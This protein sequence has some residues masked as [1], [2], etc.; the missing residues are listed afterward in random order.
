[1]RWI[2]GAVVVVVRGAPATVPVASDT[3]SSAPPRPSVISCL[4]LDLDPYRPPAAAVAPTWLT[5]HPPPV[6]LATIVV[7][8]L[9]ICVALQVCLLADH[10]VATPGYLGVTQAAYG[11][12]FHAPLMHAIVR[13]TGLA[14]TASG[15]LFLVWL[16]FACRTVRELEPRADLTPW[17]IAWFFVPF[18]N[19]VLPY[20]FI[21][22]VLHISVTHDP[23]KPPASPPRLPVWWFV[24][25]VWLLLPFARSFFMT[26]PATLV[27]YRVIVYL[28]G[29]VALLL[30]I[31]LV[32]AITGAQERAAISTGTTGRGP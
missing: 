10:L 5:R 31:S 27:I 22:D 14:N 17:S 28:S 32:R 20:T 13:A 3:A 2:A 8:G 25:L 12:L 15:L 23:R 1:V 18:A 19:L 4:V 30:T 16:G 6:Q 24:L 21:S 9:Y 26:L 11:G 7:V 29:I